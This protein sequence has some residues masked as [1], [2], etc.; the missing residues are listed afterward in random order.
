MRHATFL[1]TAVHDLLTFLVQPTEQFF[2]GSTPK[3]LASKL[4][5]GRSESHPSIKHCPG[6]VIDAFDEG[7]TSHLEPGASDLTGSPMPRCL[8]A[9]FLLS[10]GKVLPRSD[11]SLESPSA[12][13][14]PMWFNHV[15]PA[16]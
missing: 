3:H 15:Q 7:V 11:K 14:G 13:D 8:S 10:G 4:E 2:V 12:T 1:R 16:N 9:S 5:H 6:F